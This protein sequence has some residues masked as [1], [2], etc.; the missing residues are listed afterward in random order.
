ML[1]YVL[2]FYANV[3]LTVF[4]IY[5]H[6]LTLCIYV[7][8]HLYTHVFGEEIGAEVLQNRVAFGT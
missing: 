4:L 5:L 7:P 8:V 2:P 6:V 3:I 1:I